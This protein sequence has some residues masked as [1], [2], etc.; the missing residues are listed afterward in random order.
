MFDKKDTYRRQWSQTDFSQKSVPLSAIVDLPGAKPRAFA[1]DAP[2][3]RPNDPRDFFEDDSP[4]IVIKNHNKTRAYPLSLILYHEVVND[5]ING[6][7]I[8]V[9]YC[10]LSNNTAVYERTVG[11]IVLDFAPTGKMYKSNTLLC[12]KNTQSWW[13]QFTGEALVGRYTQT[14]LKS[15]PHFLLPYSQYKKF[16]PEGEVLTPTK[17]SLYEYGTT[18]FIQYDS[19]PKAPFYR[20][21]YE[22][23]AISPMRYVVDVGGYAITLDYIKQCKQLQLGNFILSYHEG[24]P[25]VL[26]E[27]R[28]ISSRDIGYVSAKNDTGETLP[29][30]M[31]LAFA[32]RAFNPDK[33]IISGPTS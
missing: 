28:I 18:P 20:F 24:M 26:D 30:R 16:D 32:Y 23:G 27:K 1:I 21:P 3:F 13:C 29:L 31:P 11:N 15:F 19:Q 10:G 5:E 6:I 4:V 9:S 22:E 7:P 12:D 25:S 14:T 2:K 8:A 17:K 33:E